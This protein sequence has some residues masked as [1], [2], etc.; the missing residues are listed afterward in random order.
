MAGSARARGAT[1]V[2]DSTC[3][4]GARTPIATGNA[5]PVAVCAAAAGLRWSTDGHAG[6]LSQQI[7]AL[8]PASAPFRLVQRLRAH[9]HSCYRSDRRHAGC[10][11][12]R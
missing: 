3:G 8:N 10:L 5:A 9:C 1:D 2:L 4:A 7:S 11:S 6:D 12:A